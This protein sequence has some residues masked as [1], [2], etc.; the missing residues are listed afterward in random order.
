MRMSGKRRERE[1]FVETLT[2]G[3][4]F[5]TGVREDDPFAGVVFEGDFLGV[6]GA[7]I[8]NIC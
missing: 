5:G 3:E 1:G 8:G 2:E 7:T 6:F 4:D